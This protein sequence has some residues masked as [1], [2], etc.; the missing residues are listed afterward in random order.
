[1]LWI[2][3][4]W[5]KPLPQC[6]ENCSAAGS[7]HLQWNTCQPEEVHA[8]PHQDPLSA[9]SCN[10]HPVI[11]WLTF[12]CCIT[13]WSDFIVNSTKWLIFTKILNWA[14]YSSKYRP[15]R[16]LL[17]NRITGTKSGHLI[18]KKNFCAC[19]LNL[20]LLL[21][22]KYY[23][24]TASNILFEKNWTTFFT[25]PFFKDILASWTCTSFSVE[26]AFYCGNDHVVNQNY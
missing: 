10:L 8:G 16:K 6:W 15:Q 18:F 26:G 24:H 22:S 1:M 23:I 25:I 11:L 20:K 9:Q 17:P 13:K 3:S 14:T 19:I 5:W 12:F 2:F 7:P 21:T 4:K